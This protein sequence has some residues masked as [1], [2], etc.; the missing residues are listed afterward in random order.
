MW[1]G[2]SISI[3]QDDKNVLWQVYS[4]S[5]A[6]CAVC[7]LHI[8][9]SAPASKWWLSDWHRIDAFFLALETVHVR[10]GK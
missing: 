8:D 3:I 2:W 6:G 7:T 5:Y 4:L 10:T 1:L 9:L